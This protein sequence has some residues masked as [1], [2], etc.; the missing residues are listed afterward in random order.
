[1]LEVGAPTLDYFVGASGD[2]VIMARKGYVYLLRSTYDNKFYVGSTTDMIKRLHQHETGKVKA[3]CYRRPVKLEFFQGYDDI[4]TARKI[5]RRLK[6]FKRKD[7]L[8][9]IVRDKIIKLGL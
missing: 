8:E 9:K 3:T 4:S 6:S 1:M 5:E 2:Y 7:F